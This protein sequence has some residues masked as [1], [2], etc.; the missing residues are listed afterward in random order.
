M[1]G[2]SSW[3]LMISHFMNICIGKSIVT[4]VKRLPIEPT[5]SKLCS[6]SMTRPIQM[7][8]P[9]VDTD[10]PHDLKNKRSTANTPR[11]RPKNCSSRVN[12]T[13]LIAV[14]TP[15]SKVES[16]VTELYERDLRI[17]QRKHTSNNP[18]KSKTIQSCNPE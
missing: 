6:S 5:D 8:G 11:F 13:C 7:S 16:H 3:C 14:T 9:G 4:E 2:W 10:V 18:S 1:H 15:R 17:N 12:K